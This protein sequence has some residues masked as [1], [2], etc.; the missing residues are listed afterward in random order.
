MLRV[1]GERGLDLAL[2][3]IA[4]GSDHVGNDVDVQ[5][6]LLM[7]KHANGTEVTI[8]FAGVA[9]HAVLLHYLR[10]LPGRPF[11]YQPILHNM[12]CPLSF[13]PKEFCHGA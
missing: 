13:A 7:N 5:M 10:R 11:P 4:P 3:D 9:R 1:Q 2:A 6:D 12:L 8:A